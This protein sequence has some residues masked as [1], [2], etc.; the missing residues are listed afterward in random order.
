MW[1]IN[2]IRQDVETIVSLIKLNQVTDPEIICNKEQIIV[3]AQ[4]LKICDE[5]A[6]FLDQHLKKEK[7]I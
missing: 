4:I 7:E 1:F 6:D 2:G 3:V 5:D